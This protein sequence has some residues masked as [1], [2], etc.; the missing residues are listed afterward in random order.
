MKKF[1]SLVIKVGI[2]FGIL[3]YLYHKISFAKFYA[4][5]SN[6]NLPYLL[7]IFLIFFLQ[8]T[9]SS[10]KWQIIL[11]A[12]D[13]KVP[14][15]PLLKKYLTGTFVSLF[16]PT[17]FGG[18]VYKVYALKKYNIDMAQN[19]SSVL[20]DRLSGFFALISISIVSFIFMRDNIV[21]FDLF[22]LYVFSLLTIWLVISDNTIK[23]F[24]ETK[25]KIPQFVLKILTSFNRYKNNKKAFFKSILI[26]F[27][28]QHNQVLIIVILCAALNIQMD[29]KYLYICVPLIYLTE[30][31]P[32]SLNGL[33]LRDGA[34]VY[35]F[36]L[37]NH[38]KEE[39]LA[40]SLLFIAMRYLYSILI[41]G[42]LFFRTV[43]RSNLSLKS[44]K[45]VL[46]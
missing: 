13:I 35:F 36:L 19:T 44:D 20:F 29:L 23:S 16:F 12:D 46:E 31:I 41:G 42:P 27:V 4:K 9:I 17:S 43:Y 26:S 3:L 32:F 25:I 1:I 15:V 34:F 21:Q 5:L 6:V 8:S 28:F 24:H 7:G 22:G 37:F 14:Y 33:G 18:D 39:A 45:V 40:V 38:T 11:K 30:A 2:S 10:L